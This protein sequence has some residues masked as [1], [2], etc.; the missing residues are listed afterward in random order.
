MRLPKTIESSIEFMDRVWNRNRWELFIVL[1][2]L[3]MIVCY[4]FNQEEYRGLQTDL[5]I[6]PLYS[7]KLRYKKCEKKHENECR[8]ILESIFRDSFS[9]VRP[10]FLKNPKTGRNLELDMYNDRLKLALEYQGIQHRKHTPYFHKSYSDFLESVERDKYKHQR[11][12]ELGIDLLIVPDHIPF[13][14]LE[15]YIVD[16]L[17]KLDRI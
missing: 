9:S 11:C 8:R 1:S 14:D 4:F 17:K 6:P 15:D 7:S 13:Q 10:D 16:G 2:I 3:A 5:Y 12:R